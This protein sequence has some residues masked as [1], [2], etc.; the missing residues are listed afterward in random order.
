MK[1]L[2]SIILALFIT[3]TVQGQ[4]LKPVTWSYL[5]KKT[6]AKEAT[7]YIKANIE[8]GWHVYAQNIPK[9]DGIQTNFSFKSNSDYKVI[10]KTAQPKPVTKFDKNLDL[11]VSYYEN[12]VVFQQ[13]VTLKKNAPLT[14]KGEVEF[15][16]C[17][18]TRCLPKQTIEFSI[19]VK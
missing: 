13:K 8:Q 12:S 11:N 19:P 17:D 2:L 5:A 14:V 1:N 9:G 18:D 6:S 7:L 10:G 4:I 15:M 16:V 3:A